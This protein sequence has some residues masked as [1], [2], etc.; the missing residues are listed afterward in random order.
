MPKMLSPLTLCFFE[1]VLT[2]LDPLHFRINVRMS[3][4]MSTKKAI[5]DF[6]WDYAEFIDHIKE[7]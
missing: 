6:E 4:L 5:W 2:S 3:F 1:V 7:S